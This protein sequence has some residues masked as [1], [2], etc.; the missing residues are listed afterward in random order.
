MGDNE[1]DEAFGD[2]KTP[3]MPHYEPP[4]RAPLEHHFGKIRGPVLNMLFC[5]LCQGMGAHRESNH[6]SAR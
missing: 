2:T 3:K 4:V 5:D 6:P 1:D